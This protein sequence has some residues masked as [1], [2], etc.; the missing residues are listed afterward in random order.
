MITI[1]LLIAAAMFVTLWAAMRA[2][3]RGDRQMDQ[4]F[5]AQRAERRAQSDPL[6]SS[7][8]SLHS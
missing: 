3:S 1:I 5:K 6:H 8:S 4:I 2:A 7:L